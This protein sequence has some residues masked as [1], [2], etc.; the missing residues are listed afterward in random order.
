MLDQDRGKSS[1]YGL[2]SLTSPN[3]FFAS[4]VDTLGGIMTSSP[5]LKFLLALRTSNFCLPSQIDYLRPVYW[6]SHA[7]LIA[8]LQAVN[9]SQNFASV[10]T[11][12]CWVHHCQPYLLAGVNDED[13]ADGKCDALLV[14]VLCVLCVK[15]VV[16]PRDLSI[17][18]G[19]DGELQI[20]LR[21][22]ID[23]VYP[24]VMG[25]EVVR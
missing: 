14:D 15:H 4:D 21:C 9:D 18:I 1:A 6:C 11:C 7:F 20:R 8:R 19:N 5:G 3:F 22:L 17:G 23:V 13:A 2:T 25:S 12:A 16:C 10:A 24:T